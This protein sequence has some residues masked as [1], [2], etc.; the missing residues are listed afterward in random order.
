MAAASDPHTPS[1][2]LKAHEHAAKRDW[3][4]YFEAVAGKPARDTLLKAL[5]GFEKQPAPSPRFAIDLG[6]GSGRDTFELLRRGWR[7]LAIDS[8]RLG[9][10]LLDA[11]ARKQGLATDRLELR[12]APFEGLTLPRADLVNASYALPF[13]DPAAFPPLWQAITGAI[14]IGGRF[15]GQFFGPRDDWASLPDR[16]HQSRSEVDRLLADFIIES[17]EEVENREAGA[18]GEVKNWHIFHVVARRRV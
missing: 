9:L 13:C 4:R 3:P 11:D 7:V 8:S 16:S 10:D 15:A 6:C 12:A 17:L 18:T 2:P 14:P 1:P 5:A